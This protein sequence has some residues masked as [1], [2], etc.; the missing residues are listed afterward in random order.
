MESVENLI[1]FAGASRSS[2]CSQVGFVVNC[3][4]LRCNIEVSPTGGRILIEVL[5]VPSSE[6]MVIRVAV[7]TGKE[8]YAWWF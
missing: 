5:G 3:V 4:S 7:K 6:L 2:L 8:A 1:R